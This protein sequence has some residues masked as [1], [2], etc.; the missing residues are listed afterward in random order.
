MTTVTVVESTSTLEVRCAHHWII[1]A[2]GGPTS[3]GTCRLC[4][5]EKQFFNY[6]E[7]GTW[8]D[9]RS[10][11]RDASK[12]RAPIYREEYKAYAESYGFFAPVS[13]YAERDADHRQ[14]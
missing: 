3:K 6:V 4:G 14:D 13:P 1:E 5:A 12:K 7:G 2:A 10:A 9:D 8:D 11:L